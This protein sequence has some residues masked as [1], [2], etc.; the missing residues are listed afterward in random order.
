MKIE[1]DFLENIWNM[2]QSADRNTK[3]NLFSEA[4]IA[5]KLV[6]A[7]HGHNPRI[8]HELI[9]ELERKKDGVSQGVLDPKAP[10]NRPKDFAASLRQRNAALAVEIQIIFGDT[11]VSSCQ[12]VASKIGA[13]YEAIMRWRKRKPLDFQETRAI[14]QDL[15]GD[16]ASLNANKRHLQNLL[17]LHLKYAI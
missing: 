13:D 15:A 1:K 4:L 8:I 11:V 12:K 14:Y 3:L 10:D 9:L 5:S 7:E 17:Q 2:Y 6:L 16:K